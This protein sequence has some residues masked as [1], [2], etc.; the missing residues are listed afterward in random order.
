M[1]Q[2]GVLTFFCGKMGA[3]KST[4]AKALSIEKNAVLLSEDAW[5]DAHYPGQINS[6]E[7]FL[8]FSTRIKPFVKTH[9]QQILHTG[10][11]IVMDFP[12]NTKKQREW[13]KQLCTEAQCEH[14]L[15]FLDVSNENCLAR[16]AKRAK[17]QPKRAKFDTKE[18]FNNVTQYFEAPLPSEDFKVVKA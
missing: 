8:H 1:K 11:N 14:E 17:E 5:L 12:A 16:I 13:F 7:D 3:G 2:T 10:T 6:F 18:V 9:V 4:K 15:I